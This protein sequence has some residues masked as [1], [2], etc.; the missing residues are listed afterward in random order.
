MSVRRSL[1][2]I[3]KGANLERLGVTALLRVS[4]LTPAG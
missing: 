3:D 2:A 4:L 1:G